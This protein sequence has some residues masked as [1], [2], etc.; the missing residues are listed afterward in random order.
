MGGAVNAVEWK[1][2]AEQLV[3]QGSTG[4]SELTLTGTLTSADEGEQKEQKQK[5]YRLKKKDGS[6]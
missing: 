6:D 1:T 4:L 2:E 3:E 5:Y